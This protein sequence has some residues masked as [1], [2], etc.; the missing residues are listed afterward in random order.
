M[1]RAFVNFQIAIDFFFNNKNEWHNNNTVYTSSGLFS[2]HSLWSNFPPAVFLKLNS[3]K[4]VK[5]LTIFFQLNLRGQILVELKYYSNS[6]MF[7]VVF[8]N[9]IK[10]NCQNFNTKLDWKSVGGKFDRRLL[11]ENIPA[12]VVSPSRC[13]LIPGSLFSGSSF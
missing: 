12:W 9:S 3:K 5:K 8:K 10:K 11:A 1:T 2:A 13:R 7:L 4:F 6:L